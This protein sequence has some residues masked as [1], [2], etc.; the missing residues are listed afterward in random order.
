MKTRFLLILNLVFTLGYLELQA[1]NVNIIPCPHEVIL[2]SEYFTIGPDVKIAC[3][4]TS[5]NTAL[6]LQNY[7][8]NTLGFQAELLE[9]EKLREGTIEFKYDEGYAKE[10]YDL[11]VTK[12]GIQ[13][14][15]S[16]NAGWFYGLQSLIQILP[17]FGVLCDNLSS[18]KIPEVKIKDAPRFSWRAFML[19]EARYFKGIDQ[20]KMLL[21]EMALLKM[22]I[23]HWH[24]VDDQG[25][26]IEIKKYPLLTKIGSKRK[27]SQVGCLKWQS[28]I[29]SGEPHEGFY[30][31]E[32]IEEIVDY[33]KERHITIVPEIEM[34]GHSTAA[35]ASYSW[36]GTTKEKI[37]MPIRFENKD[38]YDIS[39]PK[40]L[41][42]LTDVLDE[43][44]DLF[45]SKVIHI[46][47]DEVNYNFW[48]ESES[49]QAYMK[50][51]NLATPGE[52]QMSFTNYI[53]QYLQS[54]GRRM[55]GWNEIMGH[56]IHEYQDESDT[57]S[58]QQLAKESI[59]HFWKGDVALATQAASNGYE[60]VNSLHSN[61]Y[62][63]YDYNSIPLSKAYSFDP[64]PAGLDP[65]YH[66][67]VIGSGCQMWGEWIPTN[68]YMHFM[69]FPRIAAYAEVG[70]TEMKNKDFES[71]KLALKKFQKHWEQ[72]GI[73]YAEDNIVEGESKN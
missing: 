38:I 15:A 47:G 45:P 43:V 62:L 10:Q 16:N 68:G 63:D 61:T 65:Q 13:I 20:V 25:W 8:K 69:V 57:K 30:T 55:M 37:E 35:I 5:I 7:L 18:L 12:K 28:P 14:I 34:P 73:Y 51:N 27:S 24:L 71:F 33:A 50:E 23:F 42:F 3:S 48:K 9:S 39:D 54:K 44:M 4:V 70:W 17:S 72:K 64:I 46:G 29:Q 36:L 6:I 58:E 66:V 56:N 2:G 49:V 26:R 19:D 41:Q 52:L 32:E 67:K 22:N 53:S 59:V 60:I 11:I 21:D 40:V 1:Q 31:Q